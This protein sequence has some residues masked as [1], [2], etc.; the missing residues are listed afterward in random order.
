MNIHG[1]ISYASLQRTAGKHLARMLTKQTLSLPLFLLYYI[2][3][4]HS[5]YL[6][7]SL[8]LSALS[9]NPAHS[10]SPSVSSP[11]PLSPSLSLSRPTPPLYLFLHSLDSAWGA[12]YFFTHPLFP[13]ASSVLRTL[14]HMAGFDDHSHHGQT[15]STC[16]TSLSLNY[17]PLISTA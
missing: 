2:S 12:H 8:S 5:L 17:P 15:P 14:T 6:C 13:S 7:L 9:I 16:V 3:L 11:F 10:A 1:C 4:S